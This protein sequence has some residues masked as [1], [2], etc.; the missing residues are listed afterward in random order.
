[1]FDSST[2]NNNEV[3]K[4]I[5]A[6][7]LERSMHM[8][9]EPGPLDGRSTLDILHGVGIL[10]AADHRPALSMTPKGGHRMEAIREAGLEAGRVDRS[11]KRT[12][13]NRARAERKKQ[14]DDLVAAPIEPNKERLAEAWKVVLPLEPIIAKAALSKRAWASR[15]LG[16]NADD[17]PSMVLEACV[18]VLAKS[19]KHLPLYIEAAEQLGEQQ[20]ESGKMPGEQFSEEENKHRKRLMQARKWL[21]GLINN[22]VMGALVDS[23]TAQRNLRWENIDLI[24]TVM[25]NINGPDD[26]AFIKRHKADRAPSFQGTR[27]AGPGRIDANLL[28]TIVNSAI[29]AHRL[30]PLVELLTDVENL[31]T[32]GAFSWA[33]HAPQVFLL[34]PE[35]GEW[36]WDLVKQATA[37]MANPRRARADA[38]RTHVRNL[39]EWMP[40]LIVDAVE[41]F[42]YSPVARVVAHKRVHAVM[43]SP[44]E[45]RMCDEGRHHL[46]AITFASHKEAAVM[47]AEHLGALVTGED[48][49]SGIVHA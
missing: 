39:F 6:A 25:A 34:S 40:G 41:C 44:F 35:G 2:P 1:M 10:K 43:R 9:D 11:A 28:A 5:S 36:M 30:D 7:F 37:H 38:A 13:A 26:D 12:A 48:M 49:V 27:F 31:R 21:M 18:L 3:A 16:S 47:L 17:V 19:D 8:S 22:R 32:D 4:R 14:F 24:T 42:D 23:Y 46:P 20:R 15:F 45:A 33:E 29:T